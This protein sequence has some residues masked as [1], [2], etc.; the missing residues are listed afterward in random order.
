MPSD[1]DNARVALERRFWLIVR[2]P[3]MVPDCKGP[4]ELADTA[5]VLR[6]FMAANP[7]AFIDYLTVGDDGVPD[8][9]HGPLVLQYTDGRSM[10]VGR[11]HNE[12][13]RAALA[14]RA[15]TAAKCTR[16]D[17]TGYKDHA[18]FSMD[19]CDCASLQP[20]QSEPGRD[21]VLVPR[22]A[23]NNAVATLM[24]VRATASDAV[25]W[26]GSADHFHDLCGREILKLRA[27]ATPTKDA[28]DAGR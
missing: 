7:T 14:E 19:P 28:A 22:E 9:E 17:G 21:M 5:K 3:G 11:R 1:H 15:T 6:E 20:S 12:Q 23:L 24:A 27:A 4:W 2:E 26:R 13:V 18:G 8:V 25:Q 16:C 10:S